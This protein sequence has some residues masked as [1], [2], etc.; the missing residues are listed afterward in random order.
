LV[1]ILKTC[2]NSLLKS[3]YYNYRLIGPVYARNPNQSHQ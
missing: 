1:E 2:S 3:C